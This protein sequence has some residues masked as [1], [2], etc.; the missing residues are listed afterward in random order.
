MSSSSTPESP[1][2]P[3]TP[4]SP[5]STPTLSPSD[6]IKVFFQDLRRDSRQ[7][8]GSFFGVRTSRRKKSDRE[9]SPILLD[10][11]DA[12]E[13][14]ECNYGATGAHINKSCVIAESATKRTTQNDQIQPPTNP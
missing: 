4:T 13:H 10:I 3:N 5:P 14:R 6:K 8:F 2:T 11:P 7:K 9:S 1:S 12:A